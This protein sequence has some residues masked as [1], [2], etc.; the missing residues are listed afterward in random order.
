MRCRVCKKTF[1][2][3]SLNDFL[4]I[5]DICNK[6]SKL[7]IYSSKNVRIKGVKIRFSFLK[8]YQFIIENGYLKHRLEINRW[9]LPANKQYYSLTDVIMGCG[10]DKRFIQVIFKREEYT[11]FKGMIEMLKQ[12]SKV[13]K[14]YCFEVL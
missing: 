10:L 11:L 4:F 13:K 1:L 7:F 6:C 2:I 9:L 12:N 8:Y 3:V 14:I 5:H